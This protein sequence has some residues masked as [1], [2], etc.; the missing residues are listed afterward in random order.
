[1]ANEDTIPVAENYF[2][3]P[4][5]LFLT[6]KPTAI[7]TVVGSCVA[8]S[9]YDRRRLVSGANHFQFPFIGDR[10]QA[11][12]RYG[13]VAVSA[14]IAMMLKN[15]S[16]LKHL[17]AQIFGGAHNAG[18]SPHDIGRE[19]VGMARKM[20]TRKNIPIVSED[21]GGQRGRK[22]II[23]TNT[24]QIVVFKVDR[25]RVEDWYPYANGR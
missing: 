20:I 18:I 4:G 15:G 21:I 10:K 13:N 24:N 12:A 3:K 2:L 14:L 19:N 22:I 6:D 17:E 1:M 5:F 16:K 25:L 9:L 8:V 7:S 23:N 11:T